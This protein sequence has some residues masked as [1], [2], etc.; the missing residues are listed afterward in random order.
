[1]LLKTIVLC[2]IG[3][4]LRNNRWCKIYFD[5]T[6][7]LDDENDDWVAKQ[8][9]NVDYEKIKD[10]YEKKFEPTEQDEEDEYVVEK[11]AYDFAPTIRS[12]RHYY[13]WRI[14]FISNSNPNL[15][16]SIRK[17]GYAKS[18]CNKRHVYVVYFYCFYLDHSIILYVLQSKG[19]KEDYRMLYDRRIYSYF[20]LFTNLYELL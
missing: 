6:I 5:H 7:E 4:Y 8:T 19:D 15:F 14:N 3:G 2:Q 18:I 17:F 11:S 10:K 20:S 13:L 16:K 1:M 9:K 12:F